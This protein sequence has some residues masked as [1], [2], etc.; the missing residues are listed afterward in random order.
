MATAQNRSS[1]WSNP[2]GLVVG[3]GTHKPTLEGSQLKSNVGPGGVKTGVVKFSYKD[4]NAKSA[5]QVAAYV[6]VAA[7]SKIVEVKLVIDEAWAGASNTLEVGDGSDQDGFITSGVAAVANM[8]AG[9]V[10]AATGVYTA[11]ATDTGAAELKYYAAADSI[12]VFAVSGSTDW[13]AGSA[14][15]VVTYI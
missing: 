3:F 8:T 2:D 7:G 4:I 12:D 9:A 1:S 14:T 5:G 13:T 15:L 11:G 10:L 6:P